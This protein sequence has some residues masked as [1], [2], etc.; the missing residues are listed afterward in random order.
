MKAG[1]FKYKPGV[2]I[3][4]LHEGVWVDASIEEYF[5][6]KDGSRHRV[7]V[8]RAEG[9]KAEEGKNAKEKRPAWVSLDVDLNEANHTKLLF[10]SVGKY[11]EARLHYCEKLVAKHATVRDALKDVD[12]SGDGVLTRKEIKLFLNEQYLLKFV[13]FYTREVRGELDERA[14]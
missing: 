12:E 6:V 10:Q 9:G 5:G 13:D 4:L 14:C 11:E 1:R 8:T 3:M 7:R 2:K